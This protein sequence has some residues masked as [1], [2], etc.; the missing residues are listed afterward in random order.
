MLR[1]FKIRRAQLMLTLA[2][3]HYSTHVH[4]GSAIVEER[5]WAGRHRYWEREQERD[6]FAVLQLPLM[7][8]LLILV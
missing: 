2:H 1:R 6:S 8:A 3:A 4:N 5:E 7:L